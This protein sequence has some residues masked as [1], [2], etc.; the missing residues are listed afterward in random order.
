VTERYD[1]QVLAKLQEA[2]GKLDEGQP[3]KNL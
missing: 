2:A 1:R 3:F